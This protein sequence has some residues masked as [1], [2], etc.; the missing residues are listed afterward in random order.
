MYNILIVDDERIERNGIKKLLG[1]VSY[2]ISVSECENGRDALEYLEGHKV[3]VM[4]TDVKMPFVDG[5]ELIRQAA[6]LYP[7]MKMIIFSGYS[8][9]EYARFAMKM[10]VTDYILKPVD[11]AEFDRTITNV[12]VSLDERN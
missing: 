3:D 2:D 1:K 4:I 7:D 5:I 11:P 10:G 8:E 9:F 6:P 12:I